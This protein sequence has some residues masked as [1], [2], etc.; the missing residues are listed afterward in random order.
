MGVC[1][2]ERVI[3]LGGGMRIRGV[4]HR[5]GGDYEGFERMEVCVLMYGGMFGIMDNL[6]MCCGCAESDRGVFGCNQYNGMMG[7]GVV[8]PVVAHLGGPPL[9]GVFPHPQSTPPRMYSNLWPQLQSWS[10]G[11]QWLPPGAGLLPAQ[12]LVS[13]SASPLASQIPPVSGM[14]PVVNIQHLQQLQQQLEGQGNTSKTAQASEPEGPKEAKNCGGQ[15]EGKND[16][17]QSFLAPPTTQGPAQEFPPIKEDTRI[18]PDILNS[19]EANGTTLD[20]VQ[21]VHKIEPGR[22]CSAGT[23]LGEGCG[24]EGSKALNHTGSFTGGTWTSYGECPQQSNGRELQTE[25]CVTQTVPQPATFTGDKTH[26]SLANCAGSHESRVNGNGR[27]ELDSSDPNAS[28]G[29]EAGQA[30]AEKLGEQ[31]FWQVR[32]LLLQQQEVFLS[33]VWEL[34]RLHWFQTYLQTLLK[35]P[36]QGSILHSIMRSSSVKKNRSSNTGLQ[37]TRDRNPELGINGVCASHGG[38]IRPCKKGKYLP[39]K[40]M[41][42]SS[43]SP[44]AVCPSRIQPWKQEAYVGKGSTCVPKRP[45]AMKSKSHTRSKVLVNDVHDAAVLLKACSTKADQQNL[46]EF[47][48]RCFGRKDHIDPFTQ[49]TEN[50]L[51]SEPEIGDKVLQASG[52]S[53]VQDWPHKISDERREDCP[54]VSSSRQDVNAP[55]W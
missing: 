46:A 15:A 39:V 11:G 5:V 3:W 9:G 31:V 45:K 32:S 6:W 7:N 33:Q 1:L 4:Q 27:Q 20:T 41:H 38:L 13:A 30:L 51:L 49:T 18:P 48:T 10:L 26:R 42:Q 22:V 55:L 24:A 14:Q 44:C 29:R 25:T 17:L 23:D 54:E 53:Q 40:Q 16:N 19:Q 36:D 37:P 52:V 21:H 12:A 28:V 50:K 8:N 47:N 2:W 34:H 43:G 35:V